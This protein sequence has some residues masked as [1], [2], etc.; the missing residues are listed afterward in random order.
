MATAAVQA[1]PARP[2]V[3]VIEDDGDTRDAICQILQ[4]EGFEVAEAGNGLEGLECLRGGLEADVI[5]LDLMM[6]VMNGVQFRVLQNQDPGLADIPVVAV[7]AL[8]APYPQEL[9]G[10]RIIRKPVEVG[11]LLAAIRD[12]V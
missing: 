11:A 8:D 1:Q 10:A 4:D 3:L 6:P 9:N 2:R 7:T 12:L 5:L